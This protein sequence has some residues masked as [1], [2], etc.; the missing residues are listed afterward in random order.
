VPIADLA[1]GDNV[2]N[3]HAQME[4]GWHGVANLAHRDGIDRP[5]SGKSGA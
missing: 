2:I 4:V 1:E 3:I 5:F